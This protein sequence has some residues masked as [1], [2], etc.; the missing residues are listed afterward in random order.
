MTSLQPYVFILDDDNAYLDLLRCA[1]AAVPLSVE[2]RQQLQD[3]DFELLAA[4]AV[5]VLD[6]MMPDMDGIEVIRWLGLQKFAGQLVLL[7]G[8]DSSVLHAAEE[9]A[10][11]HGIKVLATF[12]KPVAL[13]DLQA[14]CSKG[15]MGYVRGKHSGSDESW[16]PQLHDL[17]QA[18]SQEQ[19]ILFY[20]PKIDLQSNR[21]CGFEGLVRWHHPVHGLIGPQHFIPLMED[22]DLMGIMTEQVIE[23]GLK[24]LSAWQELGFTPELAINISAANLRDIDF[25]RHVLNLLQHYQINPEQLILELTETSVMN[26]ATTSRDILIRLRMRGVRL[27]IDDFGT[28]YSSLSQLHRIPFTELK[29]DQRF[30][31]RSVSEPESLAIVETCVMLGHKLGMQ[32]TAEGIESQEVLEQLHQLGCDKGQGY[33]WSKPVSPTEA[34]AFLMKK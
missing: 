10:Q 15:L 1:I 31:G 23:L 8:Q 9:L 14:A 32:V 22:N 13:R 4:A 3:P 26:E 12:C 33:F 19:L 27:S 28:G 18:L 5:V 6:L 25:A 29:I 20:Q 34:T 21:V 17:T 7:S 24:Q 11:A 2:A 16:Q 30:V